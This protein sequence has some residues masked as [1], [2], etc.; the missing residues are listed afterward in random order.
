MAARFGICL[1]PTSINLTL[2]GII[3]PDKFV[4][5]FGTKS[6][7]PLFILLRYCA[8]FVIHIPEEN[9]FFTIRLYAG[10]ILF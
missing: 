8:C 2:H 10:P 1:L 9:Y 7:E 6:V 4:M 3:A 5:L